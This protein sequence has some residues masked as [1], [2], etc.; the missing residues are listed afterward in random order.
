MQ[1]NPPGTTFPY[2]D[3]LSGG[4]FNTDGTNSLN[5]V[6]S[7]GTQTVSSVT[8][9]L[10]KLQSSDSI[11]FKGQNYTVYSAVPQNM[12]IDNAYKNSSQYYDP[13]SLTN[14]DFT[15]PS[16]INGGNPTALATNQPPN[17]PTASAFTGEKVYL[18]KAPTDPNS[19]YF[20]PN[21]PNST[22]SH[23]GLTAN[24]YF[25]GDSYIGKPGYA[26]DTSTYPNGAPHLTP[27]GWA[28]DPRYVN[29]SY[30][31][32]HLD[33]TGGG[34]SGTTTITANNPVNYWK[35]TIQGYDSSVANITAQ[36][37]QGVQGDANY[38][39]PPGTSSQFLNWLFTY[40]NPNYTQ[41]GVY[42]H[43]QPKPGFQ[44]NLLRY[45]TAWGAADIYNQSSDLFVRADGTIELPAVQNAKGTWQYAPIV[46]QTW[47]GSQRF[48][49]LNQTK[50]QV[51]ST[52]DDYPGYE[53]YLPG[54]VYLPGKAG[55]V[56]AYVNYLVWDSTGALDYRQTD[57]WLGLKGDGV[58]D[59]TTWAYAPVSGQLT[60]PGGQGNKP[61]MFG[62]G[63]NALG[64]YILRLQASNSFGVARLLSTDL[65]GKLY[66][67]SFYGNLND[68]KGYQK[69]ATISY[70]WQPWT[71]DGTSQATWVASP[72]YGAG[73]AQLT[74][75]NKLGGQVAITADQ[76]SWDS[77]G[78]TLPWETVQQVDPSQLS[79]YGSTLNNPIWGNYIIVG[80]ATNAN[81]QYL[82]VLNPSAY[83]TAGTGDWG[84]AANWSSGAVPDDNHN[85][86]LQQSGTVTY[87]NILAT[88]P[89]LSML[90]V[91]GSG[92]G[93]TL[94]INT[95]SPTGD[96][97]AEMAIVG[98]ANKGNLLQT[99]GTVTLTDKL[100]LGYEKTANGT[101]TLQGGT[102]TTPNALVGVYGIGTFTQSD[103][104][105]TI[106]DTLTL[107]ANS[108]ST[109]TYNLSGGTL[110]VGTLTQNPG[111]T[112]NKT[113]GT[114]N[115][116]QMNI[117]G[118]NFVGDLEN[119][120]LL[121][122]YGPITGKLTNSGTVNPG[123]SPGILKV[124][125]SFTQTASGTYLAEVA[126]PSSYDQIV[127]TG[128]A[129]LAGTLAPTLLGGYKPARNQVFPGVIT[130]T[131]GVTGTFSTV[132]NQQITP[133]L[134]WQPRYNATSVD[135][136]AAP[137][138]ANA[139]LP[140][141]ANQRR[142]GVMFN[143][144][145]D[146]ASGDLGTVL[147]T[148]C[149]LPT[150]GTVADAYKQI[151][152]EKAGALSTLAFAGA[153]F[154]M[155]NLAQRIT[156]VRF[157]SREAGFMSGLPGSFGF[158]YSRAEGLMLAF[159]SSN[160]AG[161][162]TSKKAAAP[163]TKW[164]IYLD[165]SLILG[166]QESTVNRTGFNFNIAGFNA[167]ADYR[168]HNDLLVGLATGYSHTGASFRGSGGG[169]QTNTWPLTAYAAY[170]PQS[171]YAY[172]SLGYAL[173]LF[174]LQRQI[175]FG[176]LN[177]TATSS[178]TGNQLNAY[179]EAGY[180]LKVKPF[181]V[182][183]VVSLTYSGI[184]VDS[185]TESGAGALSLKVFSQNAASVQ[186]GVG[187]KVAAPLK[188][189]PVT[190]VPQA[191]ATYQ[192]EFANGSRGLNAS[193]S[194]VGSTFNFQTEAANKNFAVVG[195]NV[196]ILTEKN[197]RVQ[198]NYNTEMGRGTSSAHSV[199]AGLRWEF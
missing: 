126:S 7:A 10:Q 53:Y 110:N 145:N 112:L 2:Q 187:A 199:N 30:Q 62:A 23:N 106:S 67:A 170:F 171:F 26:P 147:D 128:T 33:S 101:Y 85:V 80:T 198:I 97:K 16:T 19:Y 82:I 6:I 64:Q 190:V 90:Q 55:V 57:Q 60:E 29:M 142:L 130:T 4:A 44:R 109:G 12:T 50:S 163:E 138:F 15:I 162:L 124:S 117:Q 105:A 77:A 152:P 83:F 144:V 88:A 47:D 194:Q 137:D 58:S 136:V 75:A 102:L 95:G 135:L 119:K 122:G 149:Q 186:T 61:Y 18:T 91:D 70:Q 65:Q 22:G 59:V 114:I 34:S 127:V 111:G 46:A 192:H 96:L 66:D 43:V 72:S 24:I 191:Y 20:I 157:G 3:P 173:N 185:F 9:N 31:I 139:G 164:G 183:P 79:Q 92:P 52:Y 104:T 176:G 141:T 71:I 108:G 168:V 156:D 38:P 158:N 155:R 81:T 45:Y 56:T 40:Q 76:S 11:T 146:R 178:T 184:W 17:S 86:Y 167:G 172:G 27:Y 180:D 182:T 166:S 151:S 150:G 74:Y 48:T 195:A 121:T 197:F 133:I 78:R 5:P 129:T 32:N 21:L 41:N 174:T 125:G 196:T 68:G 54:N 161:L 193:L 118:G 107:A 116:S 177:R 113:G 89:P 39:F 134:A 14:I 175:G 103:G 131:G 100:F 188:R 154:Q 84:T 49:L 169:M 93:M 73:V 69:A 36:I 120:T 13:T 143:G 98:A 1:P 94:Q 189:G 159:N 115:Y 148:L 181:I 35:H 165:P 153:T 8:Y 132:A 37:I 51:P 123:N 42:F 63:N 160:L 99:A 140:L 25:V 87:N 28:S 179:G